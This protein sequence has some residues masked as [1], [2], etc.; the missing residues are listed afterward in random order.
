MR[1]YYKPIYCNI[2]FKLSLWSGL[3]KVACPLELNWDNI[4][5][6][7]KTNMDYVSGDKYNDVNLS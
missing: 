2:I 4:K 3:Y 7:N 1:T 5:L 6:Y